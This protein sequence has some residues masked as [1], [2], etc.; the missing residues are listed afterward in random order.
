MYIKQAG[1]W[2]GSCLVLFHCIV[3]ALY[4]PDMCGVGIELHCFIY[5]TSVNWKERVYPYTLSFQYTVDCILK[6]CNIVS[7]HVFHWSMVYRGG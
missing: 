6:E 4:Y 3:M 1:P 7:I 5:S 2:S